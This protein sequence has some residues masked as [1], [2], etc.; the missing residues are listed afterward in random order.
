[1]RHRH[2]FY[3]LAFVAPFLLPQA[4]AAGLLS[5]PSS[6]PANAATT[7]P[8]LTAQ[9]TLPPALPL[10]LPIPRQTAPAQATMQVKGEAATPERTLNRMREALDQANQ[11]MRARLAQTDAGNATSSKHIS[12]AL[13][14]RV[15]MNAGKHVMGGAATS[16]GMLRSAG[17]ARIDPGILADPCATTDSQPPHISKLVLPDWQPILWYTDSPGFNL[18]SN[19]LYGQ[20]G[21]LAPGSLFGLNGRCFGD[22]PGRIIVQLGAPGR[23]SGNAATRVSAGNTFDAEIESWSPNRISARIPDTIS[24]V[25]PSG[26]SVTVRTAS[27][28]LA[29]QPQAGHFWP[30]WEIAGPATR[31]ARLASCQD[32]PPIGQSSCLAGSQRYAPRADFQAEFN[33]YNGF[34]G[35][36]RIVDPGD[37]RQQTQFNPR[38]AFRL[39]M[40]AWVV[41][42]AMRIKSGGRSHA[43][44]Y[45]AGFVAPTEP[46]GRPMVYE[47]N[48]ES[49][50]RGDGDWIAYE[51]DAWAMTPAGMAAADNL[52][53]DRRQSAPALRKQMVAPPP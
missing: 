52:Q 14:G 3:A 4:Q 44:N 45:T 1:M 11:A 29:S 49:Y 10:P 42:Y 7:S 43:A 5:A 36:H 34:K 28:D 37:R 31:Y 22:T 17:S 51:I 35:Q 20:P 26:L 6:L 19:G 30:K 38:A 40:P 39:E 33:V 12:P 48:V 9:P 21:A 41:P 18:G 32:N 2:V 53:F 25:P 13:A 15:R 8:A 23:D 24:G 47:I 27:G 50:L 46:P 16:D